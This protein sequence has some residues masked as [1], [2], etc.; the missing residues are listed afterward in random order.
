MSPTQYTKVKI[1]CIKLSGKNKS[2]STSTNLH[3]LITA[4]DHLI[5]YKH[6]TTT[7]SIKHTDRNKDINTVIINTSKINLQRNETRIPPELT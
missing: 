4:L 2:I 7:N 3:K 6:L 5:K 1:F